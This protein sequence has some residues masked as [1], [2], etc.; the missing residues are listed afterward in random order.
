MHRQ[1]HDHTQQLRELD[2]YARAQHYTR[3]TEVSEA[4]YFSRKSLR[5]FRR[6]LRNSLR[7]LILVRL[8]RSGL[9]GLSAWN[10]AKELV[11]LVL[12]LNPENR[13]GKC[14]QKQ[15]KREGQGRRAGS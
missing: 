12:A 7:V 8:F 14:I 5:R 1:T 6:L 15:E 3:T 10:A 13:E 2:T 4:R 11:T 9:R